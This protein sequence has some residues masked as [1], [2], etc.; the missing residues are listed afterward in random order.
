MGEG[1]E[2]AK[3]RDN[4]GAKTGVGLGVHV[5]ETVIRSRAERHIF[6]SFPVRG[7]SGS[8]IAII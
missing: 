8:D 2:G 5:L 1:G 3:E 6:L 7:T 4:K